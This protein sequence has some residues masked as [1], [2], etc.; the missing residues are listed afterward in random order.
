MSRGRCSPEARAACPLMR[1][2][3]F[4][5]SHHL[6]YEARHYQTKTEKDF[7]ELDVNKIQLCRAVHDAIHASGYMPEKPAREDMI[8]ALDGDRVLSLE[9]RTTQLAIGQSVMQ[10]DYLREQIA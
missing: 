6:Y 4:S 3:C 8:A 7:R 2:K 9:E 1:R 5:D 10:G